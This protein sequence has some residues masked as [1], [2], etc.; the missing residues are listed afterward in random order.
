MNEISFSPT[1]EDLL[2]AQLLLNRKMMRRFL[3]WVIFFGIVIA[4]SKF[5][6]ETQMSIL[7]L[8]IQIL[9]YS[10]IML[11]A[12]L[13]MRKFSIPR[14]VR[15]N[16]R[17]QKSLSEQVRVKWTDSEIFIDCA[18][19][20]SVTAIQD[21]ACW[22]NDEKVILLFRSQMLFNFFPR[23]VFQSEE[24]WNSLKHALTAANVPNHWP[25]K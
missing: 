4:G 19:G 6:E 1:Y 18:S 22:L 13:T 23:H 5:L 9:P 8:A 17:L 14:S 24:V 20:N 10:L 16:I 2:A 3:P 15:K 12:W 21:F 11:I 25:P 7:D